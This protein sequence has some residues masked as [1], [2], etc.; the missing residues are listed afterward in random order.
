MAQCAS[1]QISCNFEHQNYILCN[2][3]AGSRTTGLAVRSTSQI[4]Q[5]KHTTAVQVAATDHARS[6]SGDIRHQ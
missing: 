1:T 3:Q 4:A 5:P 6:E 2:F